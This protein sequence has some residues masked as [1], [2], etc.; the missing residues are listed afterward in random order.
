MSKKQKV[1]FAT[2]EI[3]E[4]QINGPIIR[5]P[6]NA[7]TLP[8][9]REVNKL[10]SNT[11]PDQSRSITEIIDRYNRGMEIPGQPQNAHYTDEENPEIP[12]FR[13]LDLVEQ[14]QLLEQARQDVK[15][16]ET[17]LRDQVKQR[18]EADIKRRREERDQILKELR[19]E[20]GLRDSDEKPKS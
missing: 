18:K 4:T 19:A 6:Y 7:H 16:A 15:D 12:D 5:T 13:T 11:I 1:N 14:Q 10:P 17:K 2:G 20:A 8:R 3:T 9:Y